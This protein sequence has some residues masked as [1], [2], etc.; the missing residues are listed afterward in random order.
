MA[1]CERFEGILQEPFH[2]GSLQEREGVVE[3]SAERSEGMV[4]ERSVCER[5]GLAD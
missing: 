3:R 4:L 1:A 2:E 5:V